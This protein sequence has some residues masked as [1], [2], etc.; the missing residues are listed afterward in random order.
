MRGD[1]ALALDQ[2]APLPAQQLGLRDGF[3]WKPEQYVC[4]RRRHFLRISPAVDPHQAVLVEAKHKLRGRLFLRA[5][6]GLSD[7]Q[8]LLDTPDVRG[9]RVDLVLGGGNQQ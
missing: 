4:H 2:R 1:E 6:A 8:H 9:V 7:A 3:E 5:N